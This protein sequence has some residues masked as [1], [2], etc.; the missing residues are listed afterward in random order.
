[1]PIK[2]VEVINSLSYRGGA[3]VFFYNLCNELSIRKDV[4]LY[5][6][7]L[8]DKIDQS[9][10]AFGKN[11]K[12]HLYTCGK[13][14][15]RWLKSSLCLKKILNSIG[16]DII[17][18][19]LSFLPSYF[20][21]FGFKKKKWKL[22]K[23]YHSIPGRDLN[24][25]NYLLEKKYANSNNLSFI[26]ISDLIAKESLRRYKKAKTFT[27]YNAIKRWDTKVKEEK[28]IDFLCVASLTPVKNH[29][30]L[31]DSFE[32]LSRNYSD[33]SLVCVGGGPL[34]NKYLELINK[35]GIANKIKLVDETPNV[36]DFYANAKAFVLSSVREGNPISILE[37]M[38]CGNVIIAPK[39]GGIP[40]VVEEGVNG[41]LY[42]KGD[43]NQLTKIMEF[44]IDN[45]DVCRKIGRNNLQKSNEFSIEECSNKYLT[46]F[47][48]LINE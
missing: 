13:R 4:E 37:A 1:M 15:F 19:H 8:Y 20:L 21:A 18:F 35:K 39:I 7:C 45:D 38:S 11:K 47:K 30:L 17:N 10:K 36:S 14:K 26:A 2:I 42:E 41:F 3:Q 16:P 22:I 6:V 33:V 9:F 46:V 24:N 40:D 31:F 29:T 28:E 48:S 27:I 12:I 44:V 5:I 34:K 25:L 43:V 32:T 23:T